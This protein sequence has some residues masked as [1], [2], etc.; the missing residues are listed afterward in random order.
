M[1]HPPVVPSTP[2]TANVTIAGGNAPRTDNP[3][4]TPNRLSAAPD[5]LPS[6]NISPAVVAITSGAVVPASGTL[7]G[8]DKPISNADGTPPTSQ[9]AAAKTAT[10]SIEAPDVNSAPTDGRTAQLALWLLAEDAPM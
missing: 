3:Q 9:K 7:P 5:A 2:D 4:S 1:S 6:G 10:G 8:S